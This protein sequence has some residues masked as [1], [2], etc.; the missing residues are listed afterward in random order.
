[1][2]IGKE[3]SNN[4]NNPKS[5]NYIPYRTGIL[6]VNSIGIEVQSDSYRYWHG[7]KKI[8][9]GPDPPVIMSTTKLTGRENLT[10]MTADWLLANLLTRKVS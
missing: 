9:I 10:N 5:I 3:P 1:M 8:D 4:L 2:K 7:R 6:R